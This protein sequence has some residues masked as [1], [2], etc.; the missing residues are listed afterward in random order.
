MESSRHVE[1][2]AMTGGQPI[3]ATGAKSEKE[4]K[5]EKTEQQERTRGVAST[6][7]Q[8]RH[9]VGGEE[10]ERALKRTQVKEIIENEMREIIGSY[11]ES[12]HDLELHHITEGLK[13]C[14]DHMLNYIK[15][16]DRNKINTLCEQLSQEEDLETVFE[17]SVSKF[18]EPDFLNNRRQPQADFLYYH[19]GEKGKEEI[20]NLLLKG[21]EP[22]YNRRFLK[23][24]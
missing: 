9:Q 2:P 12:D 4:T 20:F 22:L 5:S 7:L 11:K 21:T 8:G 15:D 6:S 19:G 16:L 13:V 18:F 1:K 23:N 24:Y 14:Q 10:G 17:S 3:E